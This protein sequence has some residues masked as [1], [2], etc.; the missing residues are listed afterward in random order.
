MS[1]LYGDSTPTELRSNFLEFLRDAVD[2]AVFVLDADARIKH[3][4]VRIQRN[5]DAMEAEL[6]RLGHFIGVITRSIRDAEKGSTDSPTAAC[7]TYLEKLVADSERASTTAMRARLAQYVASVDAEEA[8]TRAACFKALETL[9]APHDPPDAT[10]VTR[11]VLVQPGRYDATLDGRSTFGLAWTFALAIPDGTMWAS[12]VRLER[13]AQNLEIRAPQLSGWISKEVKIRPQKLDRHVVTEL[14]L[15][16]DVVHMKLRPEPGVENGFDF[17]VDLDAKTVQASRIGPAEGDASVG[18][19]DIVAEDAP[20]LVD[21]AQKLRAGTTDMTRREMTSAKWGDGEFQAVPTFIEVVEKLVAMIAPITNEISK[22]SLKAT[23]L[24][25]R[26]MLGNGRR[27]EVFV[28]KATL[29]EKYEVLNPP[30]RAFF[31]PLGFDPPGAAAPPAP[32]P[33]SPS[34]EEPAARAEIARSQRPP[35]QPSNPPADVSPPPPPS[36][37]LTSLD[38][39]ELS[40]RATTPEPFDPA[41]SAPPDSGPAVEV[42]LTPEPVSIPPSLIPSPPTPPPPPPPPPPESSQNPI[43]KLDK[44]GASKNVEL[45]GAL[46]K[47]AS[48]ART[49]QTDQAYREYTDLFSSATFADYKPEEQRQALKL[50]VLAK[51]PPPKSDVVIG[52]HRAALPRLE[53]LVDRLGEPIDL[54]MLGA[55]HVMC[56]DPKAANAA[57]ARAL[58]IERARDPSSA[59]IASLMSRVASL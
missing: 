29:R 48:L 20:L 24:V 49:G 8:A 27:E 13:I 54:E 43:A 59:L 50:M 34:A 56:D 47:I 38:L 55:A 18:A 45:I 26:R 58:E 14:V 39:G 16:G 15:E 52:A 21:L 42:I 5:T 28:E 11:V 1:Y 31:S 40:E 10:T 46:K 3:G 2:F 41:P 51:T 6:G 37:D 36:L 33:P 25:L 22:R 23:E 30:L 35:P 19:F 9:L 12:P 7:A 57:F 32:P 44:E 4:K 17:S 53:R